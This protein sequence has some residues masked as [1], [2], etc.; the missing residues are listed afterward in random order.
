M[1]RRPIYIPCFEDNLFVKTVFVDFK[2][3]PGMAPSQRRKSVVELHD[4]AKANNI[5]TYPL[6]IS[7]KSLIELGIQLS[8]FNL[9]VEIDGDKRKCT[10][11]T[12]FQSSKVF[13]NGGPYIDLL[14]GTSRSAKKDP[15]L[16]ESGDLIAFEFFGTR[17]PLEPRTAFYDWLYLN[18]LRKNTW[19]VEQLDN[20]DAF[21]DI[22]FNPERSINCQAYSVALF[23]SLDGRNML[24][25]ALES[26]DAFLEIVG[27]ALINNTS[28]NTSVQPS[29]F[30]T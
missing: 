24:N 11:E 10:V 20:Y 19:A 2:W 21:T 3:H 27:C 16:K 6:E 28:E 22:E 8:A 13:R 29:L 26:K 25:N 5:C 4:A 23:K 9:T 12:A 1:A 15:R 14:Y 17:W 18:A 30:R 7:S